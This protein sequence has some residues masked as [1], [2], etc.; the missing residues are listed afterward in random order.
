MDQ[1]TV[2]EVIVVIVGLFF[3]VGKPIMNLITTMTKLNNSVDAIRQEMDAV[4]KRNTESHR[5]MHQQLTDH[6]RR[7][8]ALEG[9][10]EQE[11]KREYE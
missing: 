6:E 7:I 1:W 5:E 11:V 10:V 3:T 9:V 2:V 8:G 4:T